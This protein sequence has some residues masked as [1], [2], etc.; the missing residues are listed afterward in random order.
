MSV[1]YTI[2]TAK[3]EH[4]C[5]WCGNTIQKGSKYYAL[6]EHNKKLASLLEEKT[7]YS[8]RRIKAKTRFWYVDAV[9]WAFCS[10]FCLASFLSSKDNYP[11]EVQQRMD[12]KI[13]MIVENVVSV[14]AM[15]VSL[16]G[17]QYRRKSVTDI[18]RE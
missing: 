12:A 9:S 7:G 6:Q 3:K 17:T 8:I 18:F 16:D 5:L 13:N 15:M 2:K 11:P 4:T 14:L 1:P 10:Q